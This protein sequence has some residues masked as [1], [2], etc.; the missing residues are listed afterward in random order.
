MIDEMEKAAREA[1]ARA[2]EA[3]TSLERTLSVEV[4]AQSEQDANYDHLYGEGW[5]A[6]Q[7]ADRAER[8]RLA[9]EA[10]AAHARWAAE[11]PEEAAK[12]AAK[13][14]EEDRKYWAR[15]RGGRSEPDRASDKNPG[16]WSAGRRDAASI[17]IDTQVGKAEKPRRLK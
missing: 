17:S 2:R 11:N 4:M 13:E 15:Y 8:A 12:Q 5:S 1:E 3:G 9:A 6:K 7:R 16:A 10:E 14:A